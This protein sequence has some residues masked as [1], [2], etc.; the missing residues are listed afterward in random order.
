[1]FFSAMIFPF[2]GSL[3]GSWAE[4]TPEGW[5]FTGHAQ[6]HQ[7]RKTEPLASQSELG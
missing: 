7:G 6:H 1:M 3:D 2:V 5:G 4:L